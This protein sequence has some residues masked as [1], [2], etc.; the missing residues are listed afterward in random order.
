MATQRPKK[1]VKTMT[2]NSV[3]QVEAVQLSI[4]AIADY[5]KSSPMLTKKKLQ[6]QGIPVLR[7]PDG[8]AFVLTTKQNPIYLAYKANLA[9]TVEA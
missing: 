9:D 4:K 2:T 3:P 8:K 5:W 7:N 6:R 1:M